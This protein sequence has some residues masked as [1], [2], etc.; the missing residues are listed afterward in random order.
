MSVASPLA[1]EEAHDGGRR[2]PGRVDGAPPAEGRPPQARSSCHDVPVAGEPGFG[3]PKRSGGSHGG[4]P[5][6]G[7][8]EQARGREERE[9][10]NGVRAT[11][12]E[13]GRDGSAERVTGERRRQ[14]LFALGHESDT[15]GEGGQPA[16]GRQ[17]RRAAVP[18]E[19]GHQQPPPG[20]QDGDHLGPVGSRAAE[21]VDEDERGTGAAH[22]P[23]HRHASD[24]LEPLLENRQRA[25]NFDCLHR[26]DSVSLE[27]GSA[28]AAALVM[29]AAAV[30]G[31]RARRS[32]VDGGLLRLCARIGDRVS[33]FGAEVT[34]RST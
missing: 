33:R 22:P 34:E 27:H 11:Q 13:P 24:R 1:L 12:R 17:R 26:P 3:R 5:P 2:H 21:P 16:G 4:A 15:V 31:K 18:G 32:R 25:G 29:A 8:R 7:K 10:T 28:G 6:G 19:V 23:A 9:G 20:S 14:H 30:V